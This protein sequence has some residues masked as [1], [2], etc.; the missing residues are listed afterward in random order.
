MSELSIHRSIDSFTPVIVDTEIHSSVAESQRSAP[1]NGFC[2]KPKR[3]SSESHGGVFQSEIAILNEWIGKQEKALRTTNGERSSRCK[4]PPRS[5]PSASNSLALEIALSRLFLK[6]DACSDAA[7]D[8]NRQEGRESQPPKNAAV[9][10]NR[11]ISAWI[12]EQ[13]RKITQKKEKRNLR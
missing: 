9:P 13:T 3:P 2:T 5:R 1:T 8:E 6:A 12:D 4:G 11:Q 7:L 10:T